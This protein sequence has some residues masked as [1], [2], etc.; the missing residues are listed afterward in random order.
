MYRLKYNKRLHWMRLMARVLAAALLVLIVTY[1]PS[2]LTF[3]WLAAGYPDDQLAN[4]R[5]AIGL[6]SIRIGGELDVI[7]ILLIINE[8]IYV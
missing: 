4:C 6:S 5:F 7:F 3:E 1:Y 8:D 2:Y